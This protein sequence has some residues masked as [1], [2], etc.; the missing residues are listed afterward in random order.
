MESESET[1]KQQKI[2]N[3]RNYNLQ[4]FDN[5]R[6]MYIADLQVKTCPCT[7]VLNGRMIKVNSTML[8]FTV[9]SI[10]MITEVR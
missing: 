10:T 4:G 1:H 6:W 8:V 7:S 9:V 3:K 2:T 5:Q